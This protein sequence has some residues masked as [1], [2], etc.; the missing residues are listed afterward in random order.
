MPNKPRRLTVTPI[1]ITIKTI[2]PTLDLV[3]VKSIPSVKP[4]P[5]A[6]VH[7]KYNEVK[8]DQPS[9][10]EKKQAPRVKIGIAVRIKSLA[11]SSE[12]EFIL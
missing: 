10:N 12:C 4:S 11:S 5:H 7:T 6:A 8:K 9:E 1:E 2:K 3:F